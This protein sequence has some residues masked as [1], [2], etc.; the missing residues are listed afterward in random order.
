MKLL[1][2]TIL[3]LIP[4][5]AACSTTSSSAHRTSS[6]VIYSIMVKDAA[7][8]ESYFSEDLKKQLKGDMVLQALKAAQKNKGEMEG[9]EFIKGD[10]KVELYD[11]H[12]KNGEI[13]LKLIF[14]DK[15]KIKKIWINDIALMKN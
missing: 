9:I 4:F 15:N 5:I 3:L 13:P 8:L 10:G 1:K 2:I 14:N 7:G 11:I 12:M 6:K